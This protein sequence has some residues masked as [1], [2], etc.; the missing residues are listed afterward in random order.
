M[1][2]FQPAE[3]APSGDLK[4]LPN[5]QRTLNVRDVT[6]SPLPKTS[7]KTPFAAGVL[8]ITTHRLAWC[9]SSRTK[10]YAL[11]LALLRRVR[12]LEPTTSLRGTRAELHLS[13]GVRLLVEFGRSGGSASTNRDRAR[14]AVEAAVAR[15]QWD[16]DARAEKERAAAEK[17]KAEEAA[18]AASTASRAGI[19]GAVAA[20]EQRGRARDAAISSGFAS[21]DGLRAA[22]EE[23][24]GLARALQGS[25]AGRGESDNALL[26]MMAAAGIEA[27]VTKAGVA[28]GGIQF[29]REELA[30]ELAT[31]LADRLPLLGGTLPLADAYCLVTRNRASAELV[32]PADFG[33]ACK[34]AERLGLGL[35]VVALQSGVRAIVAQ[36][37]DKRGAKQLAELAREKASISAVD[38][39]RVRHVPLTSAL[40]MLTEA[41]GMGF[42]ARDETDGVVRFFPN[43]FDAMLEASK[44]GAG[45]LNADAVH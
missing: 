1:D 43:R 39:V 19:G 14:E 42:L 44:K 22:A 38:L 41:E 10:A 35:R 3:L 9:P 24:V 23:L 32:S 36:R 15:A 26:D 6:I 28:G 11:P 37:G 40:E 20:V 16:V 8:V 13:T 29:Y 21:L 34:L 31:F 7:S 4:P 30:R 5:E 18:R 2:Q 25:P 45:A 17:R 12:P 33:A 27:P